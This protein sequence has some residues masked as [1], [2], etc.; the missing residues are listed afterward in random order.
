MF[1]Y[2]VKDI[3]TT[4]NKFTVF[5]ELTRATLAILSVKSNHERIQVFRIMT[6][7]SVS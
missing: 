1:R 3:N 7:K 5:L 2:R 4:C 6:R